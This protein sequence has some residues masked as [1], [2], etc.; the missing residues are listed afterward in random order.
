MNIKLPTYLNH[1]EVKE[2]TVYVNTA[3]DKSL[4]VDWLKQAKAKFTVEQINA[5]TAYHIK[6]YT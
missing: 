3:R 4:L 2:N 5:Q 6:K 1:L